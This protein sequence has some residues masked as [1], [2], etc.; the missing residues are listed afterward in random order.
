MNF[1]FF[2]SATGI[3]RKPKKEPL[4]RII[5]EDFREDH[6]F[7]IDE[8]DCTDHR[9]H[10]Y[11]K[12]NSS[13]VTGTGTSV[14]FY[15]VTCPHCGCRQSMHLEDEYLSFILGMERVCNALAEETGIHE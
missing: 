14:G 13:Q 15:S 7:P 11:R 6:V 10:F 2:S 12:C 4:G 8:D 3:F 1:P 9:F 5:Y